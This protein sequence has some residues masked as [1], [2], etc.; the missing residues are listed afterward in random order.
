MNRDVPIPGEATRPLKVTVNAAPGTIVLNNDNPFQASIRVPVARVPITQLLEEPN[1][2]PAAPPSAAPAPPSAAPAPTIDTA[3][4]PDDPAVLKQMIVELLRA[5]RTVRRDQAEVQQRL[6]ALMRKLY[7]P[8]PGPI[9]PDQ[10][11][12][13]ADDGVPVSEPPAPPPPPTP[14]DEK[15][16]SKR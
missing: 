5:L 4:L 10:P 9:N 2:E 14:P 6:D 1:Q 3:A 13:F 11:S 16:T 15:Q 8:R 7:G 12:L